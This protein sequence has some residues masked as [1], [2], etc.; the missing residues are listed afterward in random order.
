M[1]RYSA[2]CQTCK[3]R[4]IK[5]R[6]YILPDRADAN[7]LYSPVR[8]NNAHL[9]KM[10]KITPDLLGNG[11]GQRNLLFHQCGKLLRKREIQTPQRPTLHLDTNETA[12]RSSDTSHRVFRSLSLAGI[13]G[14]AKYNRWS[15]RM[16]LSLE[17]FW[18]NVPPG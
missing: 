18:E 16:C 7:I 3:I 15:V 2:A 5:V 12:F 8:R 6:N 4:R 1:G 14:Y 13:I 11:H 10:H 17:I 9:S